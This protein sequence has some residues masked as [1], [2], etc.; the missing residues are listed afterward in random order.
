MLNKLII[1]SFLLILLIMMAM[2]I[3]EMVIESRLKKDVERLFAFPQK[4]SD[5]TY[6]SEQIKELPEP[7]QRYFR[8][9][10]QENQAYI[11]YVRLKH[12]GI[13]RTEPGQKWMKIKGEEYF[14]TDKPGF[15]WFGKVPLFSAQDVYYNGKGN[16]KVKLLSLIKIV[17]AKSKEIDEG[18]LLRWLGEAPWFPTA[19]LP[20]ENLRWEEIDENSARVTLKDDDVTVE[21]I[22]HFNQQ[23]Q[24]TQFKA[25]R[26]KDRVLENWSGFYHDYREVNNMKIPM[27]VEVMWNLKTGDFKYVDFTVK[28]IEYD[29]PLKF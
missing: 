1:V 25:K 5:K 17:D 9:A 13:F 3:G 29:V 4:I 26:F 10:L 21:G 18:E 15:V 2:F 23:G 22:F 24:I 20:S 11:S 8:Y 16:L 7:V 12:D 6:S 19:L 14:I 27:R 28:K